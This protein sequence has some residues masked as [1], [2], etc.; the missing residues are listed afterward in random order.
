MPY[1]LDHAR[2][3]QW[4]VV[5]RVAFQMCEVRSI[6]IYFARPIKSTLQQFLG[7]ERFGMLDI[8]GDRAVCWLYPN[9]CIDALQLAEAIA[10]E[11]EEAGYRLKRETETCD[12][13]EPVRKLIQSFLLV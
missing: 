9:P 8:F 1:K 3:V 4:D 2:F 12:G 6:Q 5:V 10:G 13:D 7:L 11:M